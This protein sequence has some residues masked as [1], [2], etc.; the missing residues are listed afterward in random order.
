MFRIKISSTIVEDI[1][2][3]IKDKFTQIENYFIVTIANL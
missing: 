1:H 3:I 2:I